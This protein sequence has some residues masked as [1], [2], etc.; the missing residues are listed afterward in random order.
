M[1][2]AHPASKSATAMN[3]RKRARKSAQIA[4]LQVAGIVV[5][6]LR[7]FASSHQPVNEAALGIVDPRNWRPVRED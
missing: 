7:G 4:I 2:E 5:E 3:A 1:F 6:C